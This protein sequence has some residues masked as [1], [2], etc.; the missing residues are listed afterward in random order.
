MAKR[1]KFKLNGRELEA[2][3]DRLVIDVAN[4]DRVGDNITGKVICALGDTVGMVLKGYIA[5]YP[6]DFKKRIPNG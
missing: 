3:E 6:E 5:R 1:V 2:D 4:L